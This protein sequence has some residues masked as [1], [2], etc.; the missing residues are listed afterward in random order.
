MDGDGQQRT[1]FLQQRSI[2]QAAFAEFLAEL[3]RDCTARGVPS[4]QRL[5]CLVDNL[6]VHRTKTVKEQCRLENIE[7]IFNGSY[8]SPYNAVE[9]L[10]AYSKR[11]FST[12]CLSFHDFKNKGAVRTLVRGALAKTVAKGL[13]LHSRHC[14]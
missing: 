3:R 6:S 9:R 14:L 2:D 7:L 4:E 5:W 8:S 11:H 13:A 10:W 12:L 1:I